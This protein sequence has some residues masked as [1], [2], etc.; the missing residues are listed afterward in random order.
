MLSGRY[1]AAVPAYQKLA[2]YYVWEL[3]SNGRY[4]LCIWPPHCIIGSSGANIYKPLFDA[5]ERYNAE[6][7]N[8]AEYIIK[9]ANSFTEQYS[10]LRADV[11]MGEKDNICASSRIAHTVAANDIILV[12]GEALS[13]CVANSLLD[14]AKYVSK[15]LRKF[16]LLEDAVSSVSGFEYLSEI[17]LDRASDL[18]MRTMKIDDIESIFNE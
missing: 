14:I 5:I 13:H 11:S 9:S 10:V 3:E 1:Y 17:F 7:Y 2:E 15:D 6:V 4:E 18:G 16:I 12:A 8:A